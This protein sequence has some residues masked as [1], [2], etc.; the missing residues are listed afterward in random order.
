MYIYIYILVYI[1]ELPMS[2]HP[3]I[4]CRAVYYCRMLAAT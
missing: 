2:H 4:C 1:P 3:I